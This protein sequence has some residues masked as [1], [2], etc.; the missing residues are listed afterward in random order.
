VQA[1]LQRG[2]FLLPSPGDS[3]TGLSQ[4]ASITWLVILRTQH[5]STAKQRRQA[6]WQHP[7]T[8]A[9]GTKAAGGTCAT[10]A[11]LAKIICKAIG[12][13]RVLRKECN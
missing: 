5:L 1:Y 7:A 2:L 10:V 9:G 3:V 8:E 6:L 11:R 12:T 13:A 4:K